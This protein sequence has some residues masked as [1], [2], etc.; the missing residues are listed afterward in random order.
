[1]NNSRN[2][3]VNS[4]TLLKSQM[5]MYTTPANTNLIEKMIIQND[6]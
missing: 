6:Q 3:S 5:N 1:M 4:T 2:E